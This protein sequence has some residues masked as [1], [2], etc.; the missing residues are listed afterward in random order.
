MYMIDSCSK[1]STSLALGILVNRGEA[2]VTRPGPK[3]F[4]ELDPKGD[5]RIGQTARIIDLRRH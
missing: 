5:S 3:Y 4:P 1:M 2:S